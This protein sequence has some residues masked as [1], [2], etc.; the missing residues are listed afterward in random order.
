MS[1]Q[2]Y[3]TPYEAIKY[4]YTL[5]L[6]SRPERLKLIFITEDYNPA[7]VLP[8]TTE[9]QYRACKIKKLEASIMKFSDTLD[10][11][12]KNH[13]ISIMNAV[14]RGIIH[15]DVPDRPLTLDIINARDCF[16][17]N[18]YNEDFLHD[19]RPSINHAFIHL[20]KKNMRQKIAFFNRLI[21]KL[22]AHGY[23][24]NYCL[25]RPLPDYL[26]R[27]DPISKRVVSAYFR[28]I[29]RYIRSICSKNGCM[30]CKTLTH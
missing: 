2:L 8:Y 16:S 21:G 20:N 18:T 22:A 29:I 3:Y 10:G 13:R 5:P 24:W 12:Y 23:E 15:N 27:S 1:N 14:E 4:L 28:R 26:S 19:L 30:L 17:G 11:L 25:S 9:G 6:S 7:Y